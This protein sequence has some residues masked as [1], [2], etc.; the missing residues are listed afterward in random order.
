MPQVVLHVNGYYDWEPVPKDVTVTDED[1]EAMR[2]KQGQDGSWLM[3]VEKTENADSL[4]TISVA[5]DE[6]FVTIV[7]EMTRG[8]KQPLTRLQALHRYIAR[9]HLDHNT[10][11]DWIDEVEVDDSGPDEAGL[12][13]YID[14]H[15]KAGNIKERDVERLV[16]KYMEPSTATHHVDHLHNMF[17]VS[18]ETVQANQAKRADLGAEKELAHEAHVTAIQ[19]AAEESSKAAQAKKA[20][21]GARQ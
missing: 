8:D 1:I 18:S 15:V 12:R 16:A 10:H 9:H 21:K 2:V 13:A 4:T 11:Q 17:E 6:L 20:K 14:T 5:E 3:K 19:T 7:G